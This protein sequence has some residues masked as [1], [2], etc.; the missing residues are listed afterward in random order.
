MKAYVS[1]ASLSLLCLAFVLRSGLPTADK[2]HVAQLQG[3]AISMTIEKKQAL[4]SEKADWPTEAVA[5]TAQSVSVNGSTIHELLRGNHIFP[6]VE[7]FMV[8][9]ALN[10]DVQKLNELNVEHLRIPRIQGGPGLQSLFQRGFLVFFTVDIEKKRRFNDNVLRFTSVSKTVQEYGADRFQ[11]QTSQE[12]TTNS[13]KSISSMLSGINKR[14][15]ERFGRPIPTGALDHLNTDVELLNDLLASKTSSSERISDMERDQII[16]IEKD[17]RIKSRAYLEVAA[18]AV[19]DRWPD[20]KV[21]VE[22]LKQGQHISNL[23]IYYVPEAQRSRPNKV[24]PFG[25]LSSPTNE[26]LYEADYC[27]WAA[28]DPDKSP[29]TNEVCKEIRMNK[30]AQIQLTVIR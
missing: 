24:F 9:Y 28:R 21:T 17:V 23:R 20:V 13:V 15:T 7:A 19:P 27:F 12:Q 25:K 30:E 22:T 1:L 4:R 16:A 18:G 3:L 2:V 10:P 14:L 29:I 11:N 5:L 8:V 26:T 6:D